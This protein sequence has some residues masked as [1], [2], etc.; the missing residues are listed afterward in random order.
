MLINYFGVIIQFRSLAPHNYTMKI[1]TVTI[2]GADDSTDIEKLVEITKQ[3]PFVEWG[4]LFS[5][6]RNKTG[7]SRYPTL[8]WIHEF[9]ERVVNYN[10]FAP[11]NLQMNA[12]AHLC[13]GY[14]SEMLT[15]GTFNL[16]KKNLWNIENNNDAANTVVFKRTQLNFGNY[17]LI[18]PK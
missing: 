11:E 9:A 17:I 10:I 7:E 15:E 3:F 2:T 1:K 12:S 8:D 6:S 18:Q 14:T 13:G 16:V 5:P 4:I